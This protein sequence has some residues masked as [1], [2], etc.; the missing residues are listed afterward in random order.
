MITKVAFL[1][2]TLRTIVLILR[3]L[4]VIEIQSSSSSYYILKS[5]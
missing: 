2:L 3:L 5:Y 1:L 4:T